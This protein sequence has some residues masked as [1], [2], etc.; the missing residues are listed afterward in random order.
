MALGKQWPAQRQAI[1]ALTADANTE[2][3]PKQFAAHSAQ[4]SQLIDLVDY[5]GETSGLL[6]DPIPATNF[7]MDVMVSRTLPWVE[8]MGVLRGSGAGLLARGDASSVEIASALGLLH[9]IQSL[10]H[11]IDQRMQ[12]LQRQGEAPPASWADTQ[13]QVNAYIAA[14]QKAFGEEIGRAHV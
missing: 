3:R 5:V 12:S 10:T 14:G 13:A 2:P 1:E 6:F 9:D 4:V 7:L 11:G 8:A